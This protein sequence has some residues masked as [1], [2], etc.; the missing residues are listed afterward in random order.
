M[1]GWK[2]YETEKEIVVLHFCIRLLISVAKLERKGVYLVFS[3]P[4]RVT[5]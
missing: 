3:N 1:K 4:N 2:R 5:E